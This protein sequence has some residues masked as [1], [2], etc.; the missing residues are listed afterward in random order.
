MSERP[1]IPR[2]GALL[3]A[4]G[5]AAGLL[6]GCTGSTPPS[7]PATG[8]GGATDS[9]G[10]PGGA[11]SGPAPP[12]P[13][14]W[15]ALTTGLDGTLL[16][17]GTSGF[18]A[19]HRLYD[20]RWDQITPA[21]V[22]R[23]TGP[24]DVADSLRFAASHGLRITPRG[25]GH[26]YLG[27]SAV[28]GG[29]VIDTRSLRDVAYD[30]GSRTATIGAGAQLI[31]VYSALARHGRALP[32]GTCPSVGLAGLAQGGGF[33]IFDR[34]HGLTCDS[35]IG[36]DVVTADGSAQRVDSTHEPDL[37][38]A[39]RG[40]G[41]GDFAV[42]TSL[43]MKTFPTSDIGRWTARWSWSHAASVVA[44]WQ[45]FMADASDQTWANLHLDV[46]GDGSR[47][48]LVIGFSLAGRSPSG[49][50]AGLVRRVGVPPATSS[51]SVHGHLQT[52]Q[53]LAGT[54]VRES[55]VAGSSVPSSAL[56]SAG[57]DDLVAAVADGRVWAGERHAI[58]DPLGGSV[59]RVGTQA[60]AFPWRR[61]P[62]TVQWYAKLPLS[63]PAAD[64]LAAQGWVAA[65]RARLA[66]RMPG[67]YIN[68][69]SSDI[70]DPATYHGSAYARLRSVKAAY[71]PS[72]LFRPPGGV[73]G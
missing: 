64:V 57:I 7:R 67:A 11:S 46:L 54:G 13:A 9:S 48:V 22:V 61:A 38:W 36:L 73:P 63:H 26:S 39:L 5:A 21:A 15:A 34:A 43:R 24:G 56:P 27:A 19:V 71:D 60:T 69:P 52:V 14:D 23:A 40:G 35:I 45:E 47:Q 37:F 18:A 33:G 32:G 10:A 62:F 16:Q 55:F 8:S 17:P 65:A 58:C 50:L 30:V 4:G 31:D 20:P 49:D 68:Y 51:S 42:I 44:G 29:L 70:H 2:R 28:A 72:R 12:T 3:L 59:A 41:G 6:A 53:S 66:A 25:G 1:T